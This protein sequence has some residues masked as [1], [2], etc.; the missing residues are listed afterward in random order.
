MLDDHAAM[1]AAALAL[2]ETTAEPRFLDK[3]I[4]WAETCERHFRDATEGGYFL[5]ADDAETLIVRT[6][7]VYDNATPA[8]NG[9]LLGVLARLFHLTGDMRWLE[10]AEGLIAAFAGELQ[11]NFFP[12]STWLNNVEL[13]HRAVQV[14]IIGP[15]EAAETEAL[16]RA[17]LDRS[18]PN[19]ILIR[20]DPDTALP[21]GHPAAGKTAVDGRPTAYVCAGMTCRPP[22]TDPDALAD[23]LEI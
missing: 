1:A 6:K 7:T 12:L 16:I 14:V 10:R 21:E 5:T 23:A 17:A 13:L 8:G 18:L 20:L 22:I 19:R 9:L 4:A 2:F 11:R 15:P 3:A